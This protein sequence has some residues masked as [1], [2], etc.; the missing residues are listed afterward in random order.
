MV[1]NCLK[2]K[3]IINN[4]FN[5]VYVVQQNIPYFSQSINI[6]EPVNGYLEINDKIHVLENKN[7]QI[8][9]KLSNRKK[10]GFVQK[11]LINQFTVKIS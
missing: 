3:N 9:F 8:M 1:F 4:N 10:I 7:N 2:S 5:G 11:N 6:K